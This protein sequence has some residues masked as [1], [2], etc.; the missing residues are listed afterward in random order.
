MGFRVEFLGMVLVPIVFP[1][2]A[3]NSEV[4]MNCK[5][6]VRL[7]RNGGSMEHVPV[8]DQDGLGICYAESGA[9][10]FDAYLKSHT[11]FAGLKGLDKRHTSA[12]EAAA[13]TKLQSGESAGATPDGTLLDGG[14]ACEVVKALSE[15]GSCNRDTVEDRLGLNDSGDPGEMLNLVKKI[16]HDFEGVRSG[17]AGLA[18]YQKLNAGLKMKKEVCDKFSGLD[19][20]MAPSAEELSSSLSS[21]YPFALISSLMGAGCG[22]DRQRLPGPVTCE[23]HRL[24]D[25]DPDFAGSMGNLIGNGL[26]EKNAQPFSVGFCANIL[27]DQSAG[28]DYRGITRS[29]GEAALSNSCERH[30]MLVIGSR[31]CT[32]PDGKTVK[33]F[34][35]RNSWG[36]DCNGYSRRWE[37][38]KKDPD[39]NLGTGSVWMDQDPVLQ[40]AYK[41]QRID[42][43]AGERR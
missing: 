30:A 25:G 34:L 39:S 19:F 40:N 27:T 7:D 13:F 32:T 38:D 5:N 18:D 1:A 4:K 10:M 26:R 11:P 3:G 12:L 35:M 22:K 31:E 41:V 36:A 8:R 28:P 6:V 24:S 20:A 2:F 21:R 43:A 14:D 15:R 17:S 42:S 16:H 29:G 33:Q 9:A 23:E 37:C